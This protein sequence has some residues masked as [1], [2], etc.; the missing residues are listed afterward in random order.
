MSGVENVSVTADEEGMRL[1]RWFQ[2]RYPLL[3]FGR[4][5]K[6]TRTGQVRLDGQ[7]VKTSERVN[8]GQII[9]VPPLKFDDEKAE[10]VVAKVR[11]SDA[12][13]LRSIILYEDKDVL[14]LNKPH[15]LAVQ[16]GSG[17]PHHIDGMLESLRDA[18]GEKPRLVH[19]LDR[20]TAGCLVL[21]K[22]RLAASK[23]AGTFRTRSAR[24]IYWAIVAGVPI[25]HQG[26]IST[27]LAKDRDLRSERMQVVRHG[28]DDSSHAVTF[29]TVVEKAGKT[30]A[31]VSLK[32]VT[33]R[34]HQ[35]RAHMAHIG[36]GILNDPKYSTHSDAFFGDI[37]D[38]LM[39]LARR[40]TMPHPKGGILD[41]TA[42]LPTHFKQAF[43]ALGFDAHAYDSI[44]EAPEE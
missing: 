12:E 44:I 34:T 40:I 29:Y 27:F 10:Q 36:N 31:W 16:G 14:V 41:V 3:P 35:L 7:R 1:D 22:T 4:L 24:K 11:S 8:P 21:A 28:E 18:K 13:F 37:P 23:L 38:K 32:P 5:Q 33:G 19:R 43:D 2:K 42:P 26:R 6:L 39:L 9:R 20:D 25:P 15:G 17:T 30:A